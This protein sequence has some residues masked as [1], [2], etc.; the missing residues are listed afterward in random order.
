MPE[1]S[2]PR[3]R[4]STRSPQGARKDSEQKGWP[5][6]R[7]SRWLDTSEESMSQ[8]MASI[9]YG[10]QTQREKG[11]KWRHVHTNGQALIFKTMD[12]A[13]AAIDR[14]W[15]ADRAALGARP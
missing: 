10:V 1:Q 7:M 3:K 4:K 8:P 15:A 5:K 9:L 11:D 2:E 13:S 6:Y 14:L 12:E